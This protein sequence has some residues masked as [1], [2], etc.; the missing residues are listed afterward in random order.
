MFRTQKSFPTWQVTFHCYL[1]SGQRPR[2]V[3]CQLKNQKS[4]LR[5][6]RSG[7]GKCESCL[8]EGKI[9]FEFFFSPIMLSHLYIC[10][11]FVPS[12]RIE[13]SMKM[14][15]CHFLVAMNSAVPAGRGKQDCILNNYVILLLIVEQSLIVSTACHCLLCDCYCLLCD[16]YLNV[17][18]KEGKAH[19]I[20]CPAF[21]CSSLVPVVSEQALT[22][23]SRLELF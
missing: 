13:Q 5:L 20:Q 12:V 14:F 6:A 10:R 7:Q 22:C 15:H 4:K 8:S 11:M 17:K 2:Q 3:L 1:P 23:Q 21:D 9:E 16:S 18:I 19:N